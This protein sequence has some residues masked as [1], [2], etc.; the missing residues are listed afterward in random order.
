MGIVAGFGLVYLVCWLCKIDWQLMLMAMYS[1][2]QSLARVQLNMPGGLLPFW[3]RK[4][5]RK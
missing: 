3:S 4:W 5:V 2:T 1:S